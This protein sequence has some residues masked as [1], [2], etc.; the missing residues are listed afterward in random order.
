VG[1]PE[2]AVTETQRDLEGLEGPSRITSLVRRLRILFKCCAKG[3]NVRALMGG[4][5]AA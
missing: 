3:I 1:V 4:G 5:P 2:T